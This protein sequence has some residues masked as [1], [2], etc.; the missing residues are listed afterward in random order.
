V[1]NFVDAQKAHQKSDLA[2]IFKDPN[3]KSS[4]TGFDLPVGKAMRANFKL[5]KDFV[6]VKPAATSPQYLKI[7]C[8]HKI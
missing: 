3:Q 1:V 8:S 7:S 4:K 2:Q 5:N 6:I